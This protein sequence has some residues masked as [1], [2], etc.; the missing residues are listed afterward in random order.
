MQEMQ[1]NK[2]AINGFSGDER[3]QS[4]IQ[5]RE[6]YDSEFWIGELKVS[7]AMDNVTLTD[8][9]VSGKQSKGNGFEISFDS[10][11]MYLKF[12]FD[13]F[14]SLSK[15]NSSRS[16]TDEINRVLLDIG[17]V[18][19]DWSRFLIE[20]ASFNRKI[21]LNRSELA[22]F[23]NLLHYFRFR[24]AA[25]FDPEGSYSIHNNA[26]RYVFTSIATDSNPILHIKLEI[27]EGMHLKEMLKPDLDFY[28]LTVEDARQIL[29]LH[30]RK[31]RKVCASLI[32]NDGWYVISECEHYLRELKTDSL[33]K[34]LELQQYLIPEFNGMDFESFFKQNFGV[35]FQNTK[36]AVSNWLKLT[37]SIKDDLQVMEKFI[38]HTGSIYGEL[39]QKFEVYSLEA[40]KL[41]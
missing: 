18:V 26:F 12:D 13:K 23:R 36:T 1:M 11:R 25:S 16:I 39:L 34:N 24:N 6:G 40:R 29:N 21:E 31:F 32:V 4:G 20:Q 38:S 14:W 27:L 19:E 33:I 8:N 3:L 5:L 35:S 7:C 9:Y 28:D 10:D 17:I 15:I 37:E 2:E 41:F 22:Y 30:L